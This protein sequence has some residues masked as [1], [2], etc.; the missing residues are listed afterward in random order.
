[1]AN[2][3]GPVEA[4]QFALEKETEAYDMYVKFSSKTKLKQASDI[5][6]FLLNEEMKH[7]KLIEKKIRELTKD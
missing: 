7:Q 2:P 1:M 3:F 4:L 5:F 6:L